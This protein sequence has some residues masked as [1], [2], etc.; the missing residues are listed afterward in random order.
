MIVEYR[1]K[2]I[3]SMLEDIRKY[4]M[5]GLR[6]NKDN[7][8]KWLSDFGPR[9][10]KKLYD[11]GVESTLWHMLWNGDNGFEVEY[12]GDT[13]AVDLKKMTCPCRSWDL[14]GIPCPHV[15]CAIHHID[16]NLEDYVHSFYRKEKYKQTYAHMIGGL[17]SKKFRDKKEVDPP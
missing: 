7:C 12:K 15:I 9:I 6:D 8:D 3:Y 13:Y 16:N 2:N 11:N 5:N 10:R 14:T 4:A 1:T 17:N